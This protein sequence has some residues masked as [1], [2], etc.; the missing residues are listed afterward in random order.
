MTTHTERSV[1]LRED[2]FWR[3][4]V[5]ATPAIRRGKEGAAPPAS[6][7]HVAA[8]AR[9]RKRR[10][11]AG[12]VAVTGAPTDCCLAA[13]AAR[14]TGSQAAHRRAARRSSRRRI[15]SAGVTVPSLMRPRSRSNSLW[16][17]R[18]LLACRGCCV[19]L[20]GHDRQRSVV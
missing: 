13:A 19:T 12:F 11:A 9:P 16:T 4:L 20:R 3:S 8:P 1:P 2:E 7:V 17:Q 18:F 14:H 5:I 10:S 15:L 6:G